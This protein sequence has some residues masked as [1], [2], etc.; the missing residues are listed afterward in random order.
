M[1][2]NLDLYEKEAFQQEEQTLTELFVDE[3]LVTAYLSRA[4]LSSNEVEA[5]FVFNLD[6]Q[7][8]DDQ[9][10]NNDEIEDDTY[11]DYCNSEKDLHIEE[12]MNID[13]QIYILRSIFSCNNGMRYNYIHQNIINFLLLLFNII[14]IYTSK[15]TDMISRDRR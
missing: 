4:N 9:L 14:F 7:K 13:E 11:I 1:D 15:I 10:I 12:D 8:G 5:D 6:E 2:E 3:E